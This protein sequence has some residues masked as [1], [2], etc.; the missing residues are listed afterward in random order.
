MREKIYKLEVKIEGDDHYEVLSSAIDAIQETLEAGAL[1]NSASIAG[2]VT[3][4]L[5][6]SE[7]DQCEH[8]GG[9]DGEHDEIPTDEDDGEGHIMRGAGRPIPCPALTEE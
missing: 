3:G 4:R 8:C 5:N 2:T 7:H 9:L 1:Q 6:L